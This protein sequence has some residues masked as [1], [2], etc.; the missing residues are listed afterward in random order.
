MSDVQIQ[1]DGLRKVA[2]LAAKLW[3]AARPSASV[4]AR[5]SPNMLTVR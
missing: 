5:R 4:A 2:V 3:D 1:T